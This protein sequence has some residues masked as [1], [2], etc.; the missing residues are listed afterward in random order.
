MGSREGAFLRR[1]PHLV[2]YWEA[3][4][5]TFHNY[6][7]GDRIEAEPLACL[8]LSFF[9]RWRRIEALY[10]HLDD[11]EPRSL[12]SAAEQ[13]ARLGLLERAPRPQRRPGRLE[14][15]SDWNP[16]AG[17]FH[18][19]TKDLKYAQD[20]EQEEKHFQIRARLVPVPS[21]VK[22]YPRAPQIRLPRTRRGGEF[23]EVL[24]ARR[25]WRR[26]S[27]R[28][29]TLAQ[30]SA[31]LELTG[32]VQRW[33][34]VPPLGRLAL[35]TSPSGGARHP[36]ELYVLALR[37]RGLERGL[38]HY[39]ADRHR[40]E[41]LRRGASAR[42]MVRWLGGQQWASP[43][44]ALVLMT[45]VL[46]RSQW[47]YQF[48][49][50]YRVLL[51]DAGHLCQTFCLVATWLGLAPFCTMAIADS[52]IERALGIDGVRE[53]IL[54]AAGVGSRA[55]DGVP[56]LVSSGLQVETVHKAGRPTRRS[57]PSNRGSSRMTSNSG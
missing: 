43:A 23:T 6:A 54:Y 5:L 20:A 22:H 53:A 13:L 2:L 26:F 31:L 27:R 55:A 4:K 46:P 34:D 39:A 3:G 51:A 56:D 50:A 15:W 29:V 38:Y 16:A 12:R 52:A 19:S 45:A 49:R 41:R 17:F 18:F 24:Q 30:L 35:K 9:G 11:Y 33:I 40:L 14:P 32:G 10:R 8:I 1:A 37:V 57:R 47:K 25:T 28:A 42:E 36:I 7:T 21:S 48:P 44:A